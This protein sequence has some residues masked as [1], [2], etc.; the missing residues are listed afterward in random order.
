MLSPWVLPL[1]YELKSIGV[2]EWHRYVYDT[3]VRDDPYTEVDDILSILKT[4]HS[5]IK[6]T[7]ENEANGSHPF[8]D[9]RV[10]PSPPHYSK[11]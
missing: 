11:K 1:L 5:S 3:F 6:F 7:H 8:L 10:T 9:V 2:C 4:F